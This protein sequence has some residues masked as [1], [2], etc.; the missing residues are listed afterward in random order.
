M[1]ISRGLYY[2][3]HYAKFKIMKKEKLNLTPLERIW[4]NKAIFLGKQIGVK[5]SLMAKI[6]FISNT[7]VEKIIQK[8]KKELIIKKGILK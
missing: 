7:M 4:R 8:Q 3:N 1:W 6:F 2:L 5:K